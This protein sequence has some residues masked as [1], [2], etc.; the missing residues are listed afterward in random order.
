VHPDTL[1]LRQ[2]HP[3]FVQL[4]RPTSQAFRPTPKD[5]HLLSVDDGSRIHPQASWERFTKVQGC[6]SSGVMAVTKA[7]CSGQ[8][9]PV[10]EDGI[11]FPEHCAIDFSNLTK[12]LV[13]KKAK[14]LARYA[15]DRDWLFKAPQ[16]D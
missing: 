15:I 4:G 5:E 2:I 10:I 16:Q 6:R 7:E 13:E 8:E 9:L 11:P 14:A 1:L 12:S 3:S